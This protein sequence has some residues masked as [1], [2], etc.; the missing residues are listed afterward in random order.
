MTTQAY[1]KSAAFELRFW[2]QVFGDHAR[3]LRDSL[4]PSET[5]DIETAKDY[6]EKFDALLQEAREN[7]TAEQWKT[8]AEQSYTLTM[9]LRA[10]KLNLL[11]RHI[12]GAVKLHLT[13]TFVNHMVNEADEALRHLGPLVRG[14]L[15]PVFNPV[16][17]HL[18]WLLDAKGHAEGIA[19]MV[20]MSEKELIQKSDMYAKQFT[21]FY[22]KAVEMAGF[23]RTKLDLFPALRRFNK[24]AEVVMVMFMQFLNE[25]EEL[26][27]G[28]AALNTFTPLLADHMLREE[29]YYL[30]KL[31]EVAE[32]ELPNCDPGRPRV[33]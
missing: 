24:Q 27:L 28:E 31:A 19:S 21:E 26:E 20:D 12:L 7:H 22:L 14:E 32:T 9:E 4:Y 11:E 8:L 5:K 29:C 6:V 13:Q 1:E 18:V 16:H 33:E 15:P 10:Y 17:Y 3:F 23:L 30:T 2:L 25:I